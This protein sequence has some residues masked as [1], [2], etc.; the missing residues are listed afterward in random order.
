MLVGNTEKSDE[1]EAL[2][3]RRVEAIESLLWNETDGTYY[4]Y[5]LTKQSHNRYLLVASSGVFNFQK[6]NA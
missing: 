1:Y 3:D 4:D 6:L 5:D 2:Y